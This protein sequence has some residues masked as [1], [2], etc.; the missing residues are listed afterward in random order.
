MA[1]TGRSVDRPDALALPTMVRVVDGVSALL[2]VTGE[3]LGGWL[4]PGWSIAWFSPLFLMGVALLVARHAWRRTPSI[5]SH[6]APRLIGTGDP[7]SRRIARIALGSRATVLLVGAIAVATLGYTLKPGQPRLSHNEIWNLPARWDAG[8]H[9]GIARGGYEYSREL[10]GRQQ[11]VAF[12][13]LYPLAARL[14]GDLVTVPA[15]LLRDPT[16]FGNGNTR[17][18]W[19]GVLVSIACFVLACQRVYLVAR[20]SVGDEG[21][22]RT[23]VLMCCYPF[24]LFFSAAYS[25]GLFLLCLVSAVL[26]WQRRAYGTAFLWGVALGLARSNGWTAACALAIDAVMRRS[27]RRALLASTGPLLGMGL[28]SGYILTLTGDP[29]A[30]AR[31]QGAWGRALTP[32]AF[33]E[34]RWDEIVRQGV[35]QYVVRDPVDAITGL[36]ILSALSLAGYLFW[37]RKWLFGALIV[38]YLLPAIVIDLPATGRMTAVLFPLFIALASLASSPRLFWSVA[39]IFTLLQA[40]LTVHHYTW[41]PPF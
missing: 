21:G 26:A 34:R 10:E 22:L 31:A 13:P 14:A 8:W 38:V 7:A 39:V 35:L 18:A 5:L 28:F 4:L 15:K 33:I 20:E 30:W 27:G 12:F 6:I 32:T 3:S 40:L 16:L 36:V 24:A 1:D 23:V 29:F 19:G 37:Q 17:V 11:P 41:R 9:L 25:E 2:I